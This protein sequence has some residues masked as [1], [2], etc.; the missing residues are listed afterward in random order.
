M[1]NSKN[2]ALNN[3]LPIL[4]FIC[5]LS[6]GKLVFAFV[7]LSM[8][9]YGLSVAVVSWVNQINYCGTLVINWGIDG[10]V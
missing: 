4:G 7:P 8:G 5:S 6:E 9:D 3:Y 10:N 2:E 1:C